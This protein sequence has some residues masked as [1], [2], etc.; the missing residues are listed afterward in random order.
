MNKDNSRA[1]FMILVM[2]ILTAIVSSAI[3]RA[4]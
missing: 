3:E 2:V 4:E 1:A